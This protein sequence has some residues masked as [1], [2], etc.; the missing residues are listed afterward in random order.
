[1]VCAIRGAQVR[2]TLSEIQD[3]RLAIQ[4]MLQSPQ[5]KLAEEIELIRLTQT[6]LNTFQEKLKRDAKVKKAR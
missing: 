4:D 6:K 1:M 5:V 3:D 2:A